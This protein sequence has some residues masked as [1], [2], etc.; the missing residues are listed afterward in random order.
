MI[1]RILERFTDRAV[2]RWSVVTWEKEHNDITEGCNKYGETFWVQ[3]WQCP[4][5][6]WECRVHLGCPERKPYCQ[7]RKFTINAATREE[8]MARGSEASYGI[9]MHNVYLVP[10]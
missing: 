9:H 3:L 1:R 10:E 2:T 4:K 7:C 5:P 8:A 6:H